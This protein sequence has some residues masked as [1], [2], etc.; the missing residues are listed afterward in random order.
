M[1]ITPESFLRDQRMMA[2][3]MTSSALLSLLLIALAYLWAQSTTSVDVDEFY[4]DP[5]VLCGP[6][7]ISAAP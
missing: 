3:L 4:A 1:A 6:P 7:S 2:T 5:V